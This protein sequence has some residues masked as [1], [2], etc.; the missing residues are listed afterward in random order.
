MKK[1]LNS[2]LVKPA[3]ADCN[4]ACEYCF[5]RSKE[6]LYPETQKHRMDDGVLREMIRQMLEKGTPEVSFCWQGGEP[7]LLGIDFFKRAVD[8]QIQY[9]RGKTVGNAIQTNGVL[10]DQ[11]WADFLFNYR[12]LTGLS[13]DGPRHVHDRYRR[14][15]GGGASW[16][17]TFDATKRLL[18]RNVLVNALSVINDYSS[19]YPEE[20]YGFLKEAGLTHMQFIPCVETDPASPG[21]AAAYSVSSDDYGNFLC[22]IFDLWLSDFDNGVPGTSIRLFESLLFSYAKMIP[23]DCALMDECGA[24]LVVE[25]NGDVYSC[26]FFVTPEHKLGNIMNG[27]LDK[28]L[29]SASQRNFGRKKK[30][31]PD[32]CENCAYLS[33]CRG[34]CPKDRIR[35]PADKGVNHFC[36]AYKMFFDHAGP[37]LQNIVDTWRKKQH[38]SGTPARTREKHP[39]RN[40]P[41]PCDSGLKY[42]KCCGSTA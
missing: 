11:K 21:H 4:M 8:Y 31:P 27:R 34:G 23:P 9:G 12:F 42:K 24:Y 17:K 2:L 40:Q 16:E 30:T 39:G 7:T 29:N 22:R 33:H 41:C 19:Q 13:I 36:G 15:A 32:L 10:I 26:D 35:D 1:P 37:A 38:A 6:C 18:D 25:Y 14:M 20:I 28:M 5:Y 3:G